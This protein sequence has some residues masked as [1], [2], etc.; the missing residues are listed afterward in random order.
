MVFMKISAIG[1]QIYFNGSEKNYRE[2]VKEKKD[3]TLKL[4][5]GT[6][7]A[8]AG[9]LAVYYLSKGS[10]G[11]SRAIGQKTSS[12]KNSTVADAQD[13]INETVRTVIEKNGRKIIK[14]QT[15]NGD[16][17]T[18]EKVFYD[19]NGKKIK[20]QKAVTKL[21]YI[22]GIPT[23]YKR[24]ITNFANNEQTTQRITF[25]TSDGR[26]HKSI[27]NGKTVIY[28]YSSKNPEKVIGHAFLENN[29][30][31][32]KFNNNKN[33]KKEFPNLESIYK[34]AKGNFKSG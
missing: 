22:V 2:T 23:G 19:A 3:T 34:W 18:I 32:L 14:T 24:T 25:L 20:K 29:K 11:A 27:S 13:T 12:G 1:P 31:I 7:I 10:K 4:A 17:E 8:G 6:V 28:G 30:F 33:F 15:N 5:I 26:P 16:T 9:L 21:T